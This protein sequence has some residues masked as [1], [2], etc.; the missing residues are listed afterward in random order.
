MQEACEGVRDRAA[1]V[2]DFLDPLVDRLAI[3][4]RYADGMRRI[5]AMLPRLLGGKVGRFARTDVFNLA[6]DVAEAE[7][8]ARGEDPSRV[9]R[10]RGP[11]APPPPPQRYR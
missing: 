11:A 8:V 4:R 1:A 7:L 3:S 9:Q 5:V 10:L 2:A 6:L